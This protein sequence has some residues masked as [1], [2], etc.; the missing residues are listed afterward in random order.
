M[1]PA[2]VERTF[3][4]H[5]HT[6]HSP[7][8][9]MSPADLVRTAVA[10]SLSGIA[11]TDHNSTG[12]IK[13]AREEA[14]KFPG[15]IVI[16]GIEVSS[17]EGHVIG[18]GI[19]SPIASGLEVADTVEK[20]R[21]AGGLPVAAH[22]YRRFTGIGEDCIRASRFEAVE[23]LNGRSPSRKNLRAC[24][25]SVELKQGL[26]AGSDGHKMSEVGRCYIVADEDPGSAEGLLEL[27]RR[28]KVRTWGRSAG[29]IEVARTLTKITTEL[30]RRRGKRI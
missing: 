16:P 13:A 26:S 8:G 6:T 15:F 2:S 21:A 10:R 12:G 27:I 25:L 24:R 19:E 4:L 11:L 5:L 1:A 3:D 29:V 28:R 14:A 22:P 17:R 9:D 7:D 20:I 23:V 18:L 30:L